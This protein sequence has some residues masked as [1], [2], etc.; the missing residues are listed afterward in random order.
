MSSST[1]YVIDPPSL[2]ILF[3]VLQ[4][5]NYRLVGPTLD[6]NTIVYDEIT[7]VEDLPIGWGDDQE[8]GKYRLRK[9]DDKALFGFNLGPHSWKKLLFPSALK[10]FSS[11]RSKDGSVFVEG[12]NNGIGPLRDAFAGVQPDRVAFIGVRACELHAVLI[13]D[14]VFTGTMYTDP[15]YASLRERSFI[16]AVNCSQ[17]ASTCFCTS[18]NTGPKADIGFDLCL[19]EV[20]HESTHYF[21]VEIGSDKGQEVMKDLTYREAEEQEVEESA[22]VVEGTAKLMEREMDTAD[23]KRLLQQN[24]DHPHWEVIANRCL[25]CANCTMVCPTCFCHTVEDTTDLTGMHAERWRKWDSC[26]TVE[27]SYIHGGSIRTS[28]KSR[29]RQWLTHKL[30]NWIDQFGTSGC[31]GCGRCITWC[32]VGID[33]TEE[34]RT[35]RESLPL[36]KSSQAGTTTSQNMN[37]TEV[38]HHGVA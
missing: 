22:G 5:R 24:L 33:I 13:Q 10:L 3:S 12:G 23:I 19:T 18:M 36:I 1:R 15:Y 11:D 34:V 31:V 25:S 9:R 6:D 35:L 37:N 28:P 32:P 26:F 38:N 29:Y 30:A 2:N 14:R 27:F 16:V 17:A 8:P 20:L 7:T 4:L 21:L